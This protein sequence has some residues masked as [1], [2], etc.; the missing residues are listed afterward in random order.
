MPFV[1]EYKRFR[2][3]EIEAL[4]VAKTSRIGMGLLYLFLLLVFSGIA[5]LLLLLTETMGPVTA[6]LL[7]VCSLAGLAV[8]ALLLRHL[9]LGPTCVCDLQTRL[10]RERLRPLNRYHHALET[11]RRVEGLVR[12]SQAG[13]LAA[14]ETDAAARPT[15][16]RAAD[17]YQVPGP[18][19]ASFAVFA[20][21]GFAALAS[22]F[23]ENPAF[24]G[25]V[26]LFL[27]GASLLLILALV[28]VVR[29]PTP[30]SIR[31]V[32]WALLALHFLVVGTGTVYFLVVAMRDG[33][34]AY[35]VGITG[36]LEAFAAISSEGGMVL[37]GVFAALFLGFSGAG[38]WGLALSRKWKR[39]IR[40]AASLAEEPA[41]GGS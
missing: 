21:L 20:L 38:L 10:T 15:A 41:P 34:E 2:L 7:S 23:L 37:H 29:K 31:T 35:T 12:E 8:A 14:G 30:E 11:V 39:Q 24:A 22:L 17:F 26:L 40:L 28:S 5:A 13:I 18:V 19:P 3:D 32:L 25:L 6:I 27:L 1:E 16:S 4:T 36:P 33:G 9:V